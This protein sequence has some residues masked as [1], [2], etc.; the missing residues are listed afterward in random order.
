MMTSIN[1]R[2]QEEEKPKAESLLN[3][4]LA[5]SLAVLII[6]LIGLGVVEFLNRE[7]E[8]KKASLDKRISSTR[9]TL[10]SIQSDQVADFTKRSKYSAE[11]I[12]SQPDQIAIL[13]ALADLMQAGVVISELEI[14]Q[15]GTGSAKFA[16]DNFA[17]AAKQMIA[18]K[19]A[20]VFSSLKLSEI[21]KTEKIEFTAEFSYAGK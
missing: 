6:T 13:D 19:R 18:V 15:G 1:L 9:E 20:N 14:K 16:A 12:K 21:A 4:G 11:N 8:S 2:Q 17:Q 7:A 10:S 3:R 5:L